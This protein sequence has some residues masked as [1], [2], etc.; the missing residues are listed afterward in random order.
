MAIQSDIL[1]NGKTPLD[2][3]SLFPLDRGLLILLQH[4]LPRHTHTLKNQP[5]A[6]KVRNQCAH[7]FILWR[8]PSIAF[9]RC[10]QPSTH[11]AWSSDCGAEHC[12]ET[13]APFRL[14]RHIMFVEVVFLLTDTASTAGWSSIIIGSMMVIMRMDFQ[15]GQPA[16]PEKGPTATVAVY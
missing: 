16:F 8:H 14:C 9:V 7:S 10:T 4:A 11:P 5:R 2:R 15:I 13:S 12:P 3:R 6:A 1:R